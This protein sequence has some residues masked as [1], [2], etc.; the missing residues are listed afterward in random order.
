MTKK[1]E[2]KVEASETQ[3]AAAPPVVEDSER[4]SL[5]K[6]YEESQSIE[7][8][9]PEDTEAS[10]EE[11][12]VEA[13]A[14]SEDTSGDDTDYVPE[15]TEGDAD[16]D[17]EAE[18]K[19]E[20]EKQKTVPYD[21]FHQERERRKDL[22]KTVADLE[23]KVKMLLQDNKV[24]ME[25]GKKPDESESGLS[26]VSEL[27][28]LVDDG[29]YGDAL[30]QALKTITG[31]QD[32]IKGLENNDRQRIEAREADEATR[33]AEEAEKRIQKLHSDLEKEGFPGFDP[34]V[35]HVNAELRAMIKEDPDNI[36]LNNDE[37][38]KKIYKEKVF[39][40]FRKMFVGKDRE[41][42]MQGKRER[43]K[44][45]N[46]GGGGNAPKGS[47]KK[48]NDDDWGMN[49]YMDMRKEQGLG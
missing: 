48:D 19:E 39:P 17:D 21:A 32:T 24:L 23:D 7:E 30:K 3:P 27:E 22:Q 46:L 9:K 6:S 49:D 4:D 20:E 38:F 10:P 29:E 25:R 28:K 15:E 31:L 37:G 43:K 18:D 14:E 12:D 13:E 36:S 2:K 47:A 44:N 34:L 16:D 40:K 45:A 26:D 11:E 33:K 1:G 41:D 8:F 35:E 42:T 5:Y